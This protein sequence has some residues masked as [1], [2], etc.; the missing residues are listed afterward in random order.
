VRQLPFVGG[1]TTKM[2][3]AMSGVPVP[4]SGAVCEAADIRD[5]PSANVGFGSPRMADIHGVPTSLRV[6]FACLC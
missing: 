3:F 1:D 2:L 5:V 4:M 6:E